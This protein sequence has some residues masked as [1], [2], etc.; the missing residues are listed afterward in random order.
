MFLTLVHDDYGSMVEAS[1]A[2]A[3]LGP[4]P[5]LMQ[6]EQAG[7]DFH[8]ALPP[9]LRDDVWWTIVEIPTTPPNLLQAVKDY[10]EEME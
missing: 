9:G 3:V 8:T 2:Q 7:M 10:V 5:N 6:A 4:Y 1:E